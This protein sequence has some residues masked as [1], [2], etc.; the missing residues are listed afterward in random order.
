MS[1]LDQVTVSERSRGDYHGSWN[2]SAASW[3]VRLGCC[4]D[5]GGVDI[6][7]DETERIKL[8]RNSFRVNVQG[9]VESVGKE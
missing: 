9:I 4:Y 8:V 2:Q 6:L 1:D 7:G 5:D 3:T